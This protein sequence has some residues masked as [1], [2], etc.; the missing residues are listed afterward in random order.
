MPAPVRGEVVRQLGN[1]FR[2]HKDAYV[3]DVLKILERRAVAGRLP[4]RTTDQIG[5][6]RESKQRR[7]LGQSLLRE[8]ERVYLEARRRHPVELP[9]GVEGHQ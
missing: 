6:L 1:E 7:R 8:G 4:L 2:R 9:S 3:S 5:D